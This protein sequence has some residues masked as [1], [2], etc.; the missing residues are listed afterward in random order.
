MEREEELKAAAAKEEIW[1]YVYGFTDMAVVKCAIELG[2]ADALERH[3]APMPLAQLSSVLRCSSPHLHRIMRFLVHRQIFKED[4]KGYV[5]TP[6][7]R[8]LVRN[9]EQSMAAL[10]LLESSPMMLAPWHGLSARVQGGGASAPFTTAH[11]SDIWYYLA[12]NPAHSKMM[13]D[14]MACDA[15]LLVPAVVDGC[16]KLFDGLRTLVD[17]GGGNGTAMRI[18]VKACPWL[19]GINFDLPHVVATAQDCVG[20]EHVAGD[21]FHGVP[22][23]DA[24][25]LMKVLHD[26]GDEECIQILRRCREAIDKDK[27][28]VIIVEAVVEEEEEEDSNNRLEYARLLLDMAMLAHTDT[29]KERTKGEWTHLL[30]QA[31]FT[32]FT[33]TRIHAIPSVIQA[34]P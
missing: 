15:R 20:V 29:G 13:D 5:Q 11:G 1:K 16:P 2:I 24:A 8:L 10:V 25:Y 12:A 30:T 34:W 7:S 21:M 17:V 32:L 4:S 18:L 28:K 26:W 31:G 9:G 19:C 22:K 27:G 6:I 23:A 3:Q 14:G 33:F